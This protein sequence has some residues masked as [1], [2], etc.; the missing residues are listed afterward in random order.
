MEQRL[1]FDNENGETVATSSPRPKPVLPF[2][3]QQV[4]GSIPVPST[5][6]SEFLSSTSAARLDEV[7][8]LRSFFCRFATTFSQ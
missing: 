8:P 4:T 6:F 3:N 5:T 7:I 1:C 2:R